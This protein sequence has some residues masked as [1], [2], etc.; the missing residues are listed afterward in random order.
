MEKWGMKNE[1][2]EKRDDERAYYKTNARGER[3][4]IPSGNRQSCFGNL[5]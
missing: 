1:S 3:L 5:I 4:T 2:I